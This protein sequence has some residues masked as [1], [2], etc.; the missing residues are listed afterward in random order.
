MLEMKLNKVFGAIK[1]LE[2]ILD[3]PI[4]GLIIPNEQSSGVIRS[5]EGLSFNTVRDVLNAFEASGATDLFNSVT[6]ASIVNGVLEF[7][8]PVGTNG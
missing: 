6:G 4:E 5:S 1:G 8:Q 2:A 3:E 7:S